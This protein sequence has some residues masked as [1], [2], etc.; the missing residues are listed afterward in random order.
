[1]A[2]DDPKLPRAVLRG[3]ELFVGDDKEPYFRDAD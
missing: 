2:Y 1:M 3:E